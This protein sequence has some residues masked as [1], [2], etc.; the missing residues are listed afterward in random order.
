MQVARTWWRFRL[1][2][3]QEGSEMATVEVHQDEW[4]TIPE[5]MRLLGASRK[6][7]AKLMQGGEI[8]VRAVPHAIPKLLRAD[9]ETIAQAATKPRRVTA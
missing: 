2:A 1:V 4:V 7:I 3:V 9:V 8:T 5:A 6:V